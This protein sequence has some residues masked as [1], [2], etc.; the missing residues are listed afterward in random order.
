VSDPDTRTEQ[1]RDPGV[2]V[3]ADLGLSQVGAL[4]PTVAVEEV[5]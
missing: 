3:A 1:W 2:P 4:G 5:R